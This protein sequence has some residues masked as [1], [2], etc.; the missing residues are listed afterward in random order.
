MLFTKYEL[1]HGKIEQRAEYSKS[2]IRTNVL[3]PTSITFAN[4]TSIY[5]NPYFSFIERHTN[6]IATLRQYVIIMRHIVKI[7]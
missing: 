7:N 1:R 4:L 6:L 2:T 5:K 3:C